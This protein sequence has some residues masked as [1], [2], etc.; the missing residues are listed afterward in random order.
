MISCNRKGV[1]SQHKSDFK[2][3]QRRYRNPEIIFK[4]L[5][6]AFTLHFFLPIFKW[7]FLYFPLFFAF[8]FYF[9]TNC[10]KRELIFHN[11]YLSVIGDS[12]SGTCVT[13]CPLCD[14]FQIFLFTMDI[15]ESILYNI[16]REG[17]AIREFSPMASHT[18]VPAVEGCDIMKLERVNENQIKCTLSRGDLLD[19]QINLNELAYGSEKA[20]SLFREMLNRASY[21][22]DF[23]AE[24]I[25]LMIEAIPMAE[26]SIVLLITKMEDPE[27]L[28]TRFA[29]FAP[30]NIEELD[31]DESDSSEQTKEVFARADEILDAFAKNSELLKEMGDMESAGDSSRD[32]SRIFSFRDL[33]TVTEA[34]HAVSLS[35]EGDNALYKNES[36]GLYYLSVHKSAHTPESFNQL[37]NVLSEYGTIVGNT[38]LATEAYL[39]EHQT[40]LIRSKALQKLR[41]L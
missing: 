38:P 34:A 3:V 39:E 30:G 17:I 12:P 11:L 16:I 13:F 4:P 23:N 7:F 14:I 5:I 6:P 10:K 40:I 2:I 26:D 1:S 8:I 36:N 9:F 25:P 20:R 29:K 21:E 28:D 32:L 18:K 33:D 41:N 19:R 35:Y 24:D 22:L 27:E 31:L 37:C 15:S